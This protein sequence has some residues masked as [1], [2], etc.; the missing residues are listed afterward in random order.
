[1]QAIVNRISVGRNSLKQLRADACAELGEKFVISPEVGRACL[2]A[3]RANGWDSNTTILQLTMEVEFPSAIG[4]EDCLP[5]S[6]MPVTYMIVPGIKKE[7]QEGES[8]KGFTAVHAH[9]VNSDGSEGA[10]MEISSLHMDMTESGAKETFHVEKYHDY[11]RGLVLVQYL[12]KK[13]LRWQPAKWIM[14]S[15]GVQGFFTFFDL[16]L[17][18]ARHCS[19]PQLKMYPSGSLF[20]FSTY[21]EAARLYEE[22]RLRNV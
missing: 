12:G 4:S 7:E 2:D 22:E 11:N 1:M 10:A 17:N 13:A 21:A 5:I 19:P 9:E 6:E 14:N 3:S 8:G 15:L 20:G 18:S 16:M